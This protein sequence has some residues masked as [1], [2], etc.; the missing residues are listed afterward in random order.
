MHYVWICFWLKCLLL[1][2][3]STYPGFI[4]AS[5]ESIADTFIG[6]IN[7]LSLFVIALYGRPL[8]GIQTPWCV[9]AAL[10]GDHGGVF[11]LSEVLVASVLIALI[12][13]I[14]SRRI[15]GF[16]NW[17]VILKDLR[18][19]LILCFVVLVWGLWILAIMSTQ[20]FAVTHRTF[21]PVVM[22][23]SI[24]LM[25]WKPLYSTRIFLMID[26]G[27][28]RTLILRAVLLR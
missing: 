15:F 21:C 14:F 18:R 9:V 28:P 17:W 22:L 6:S 16:L 11:N 7:Y 19:G 2:G 3:L 10:D 12:M 26:Y 4:F 13:C 24:I 1:E 5:W 8:Q 27:V 20:I 23:S 25:T